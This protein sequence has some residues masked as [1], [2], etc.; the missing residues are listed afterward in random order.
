MWSKTMSLNYQCVWSE[1]LLNV[2]AGMI[3]FN[4]LWLNGLSPLFP[5]LR[6]NVT[7]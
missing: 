2:D 7:Y 1:A 3:V 6:H 4:F 5:F